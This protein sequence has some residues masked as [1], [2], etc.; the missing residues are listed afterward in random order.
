MVATLDIIDTRTTGKFAR[1]CKILKKENR[2]G[3]ERTSVFPQKSGVGVDVAGEMSYQVGGGG[4]EWIW[5][6][7]V[8][9]VVIDQRR[10][11]PPATRTRSRTS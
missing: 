11:S 7:L 1:V 8:G 3:R 5:G 9:W 10:A 4:E 2:L 6:P